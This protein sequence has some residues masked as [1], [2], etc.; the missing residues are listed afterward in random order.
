MTN[1]WVSVFT[2]FFAGACMTVFLFSAQAVQLTTETKEFSVEPDAKIQRTILTVEPREYL[3]TAAANLPPSNSRVIQLILSY[4]DNGT[5]TYWWPKKG[6]GSYDGSTT[7]VV[8]NGQVVMKGEPQQRTFCCGLTLEVFYK[9]LSG[10]AQMAQLLQGHEDNFKKDWFCRNIDSP[11]PAEAL[12]NAKLGKRITN[13]DDAMPGDFVQ[14]WRTSKSGHSVI[15]INWIYDTKGE[16]IGVQYWSTQKST[17][18][19]GFNSELF[20]KIP[21]LSLIDVDKLSIA[22]PTF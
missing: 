2:K 13:F 19:I 5:H 8:L 14:I 16:R 17:R 20:G 11:G 10:N 18:G 3:K 1:S 21:G 12:E 6:E 15:F 7:D 4:P 22:R 9:L